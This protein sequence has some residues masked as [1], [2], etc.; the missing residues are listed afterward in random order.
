MNGTLNNNFIRKRLAILFIGM[1]ICTGYSCSKNG[2]IENQ[3]TP[4]SKVSL[5][6]LPQSLQ[7]GS[8]NL[9]LTKETTISRDIEGIPHELLKITLMQVLGSSS[10]SNAANE[11]AFI[12]ISKDNTLGDEGYRINIDESINLSYK[13]TEGLLWGIQTLRQILLQHSTTQNSLIN[14]PKLIISDTPKKT[15]RGF[16]IDLAR[17]MFNLSYLKKIAD[18]LSFYKINKLQL[19]LTDDQGWR[20][21]VKKYPMLTMQGGWREFDEYDKRC[22]ELSNSDIDFTIDSRFIRNNSEYGGYYTQEEMKDFITYATKRGIDVIP[23]IDMPGHFS[24]AIK[25]FPELSCTGQ[26][27]WGKEFSYP[28]CAGRMES[29][30]FIK[31]ILDEISAL[32]PS[33]YIHIG[34]D[35]VEMDNWKKCERCQG[36][37]QEKNL[38]DVNGLKNYFVEQIATYAKSKGKTVMAWDDAY[39]GNNPQDLLYTY[40]RDWLPDEPGEIT[41]KGYPLIFMEW[42]HFYLSATPS[43]DLLKSLYQFNL[44]PKFQGIIKNKFLGYQACVWTEMIPN[45]RKFGQHT[46][47]SLQAFAELAWDSDRNWSNFTERLPWHLQWLTQNGI[48]SRTPGFIK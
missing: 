5:I 4:L 15:W 42:G 38:K 7:Y 22:I 47:P 18:V 48:H 11:E 39:I 37:I 24:A 10:I 2:S 40:W 3:S 13:T 29:Y 21:E 27:G 32:F 46:F 28:I 23:E 19:H 26:A 1:Q 6:P 45:E 34:A 17:H 8:S 35:E 16:H 20:I 31:N 30:A 41:Q 25:V 33:E 44:E 43:D 36:L 9:S 14:I 12:R